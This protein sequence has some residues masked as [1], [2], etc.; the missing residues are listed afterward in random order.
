MKLV[1]LAAAWLGGVFLGLETDV[2]PAAVYLFMGATL[3]LG[4]AV[5]V[6]R[7]PVF[8][9]ILAAFLLAGLWRTDFFQTETPLLA[10]QQH[11]EVI[12]R[13]RVADDPETGI[14]RPR[15]EFAVT[16]ID[17]GDGHE[18]AAGRLLVYA[19]PS[20]EMA[21]RRKAPYFRHGDALTVSGNLQIPSPVD[22]YDYPAYLA[23]RGITGVL[24]AREVELTAEGGGWRGEVFSVRRRLAESLDHALPYPH[25]SL[26]QALLLGKRDSLPPELVERF[27]DTG[28]AHLLAISGL[29]VG[30]ILVVV[31]AA[32]TSVWGRQRYIYLVWPLLAVWAYALVSGGSPPVMRAAAMGTV[33]LAA[34]A[35]GRPSSVLPALAFAAAV[36][37]AASPGLLKQISFQ[38]SFVAVAGIA[39]AHSYGS[40]A[41]PAAWGL[42]GWRQRI[43]RP[44]LGLALVSV[45]AALATWPLVALYFDTV[46]LTGVPITMLAVPAMPFILSGSLL[47]ALLDLASGTLG[48]I[49]GTVVWVPLAYLIE[50]V[51]MFPTWNWQPAWAS[52]W[53]AAGWYGGLAIL[54]MAAR[55]YQVRRY[56]E[57]IQAGWRWSK[58]AGFSPRFAG[59]GIAAI[60][61]AAAASILWH[62]AAEGPDGRLQVDIFDVGQ[63][64]SILVTTPTGRRMLVDGGPDVD[65]ATRALSNAADGRAL[66]LV[67]LTHLDADHSRGL[68]KVL[69]RYEVGAVLVGAAD[70]DAALGPQWQS[71]LAR[72]EVFSV[73]V[74]DGYQVHLDAGVTLDVLNPASAEVR[75]RGA[76]AN[77]DGVVL[78]LAY[79]SMSFLLAAD[80]ERE[81]E[82][83]LANRQDRLASMVIK[84]AHHGSSTSSTEAFLSGVAPKV[85]VIS[86][87]SDN[88]FGHPS[89][90][91]VDRLETLVSP[92]GLFRTDRDGDVRLLTDGAAL[93]VETAR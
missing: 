8:P 2:K 89:P 6:A 11:Q 47:A 54:L 45:A 57:C 10:T 42:E 73:R 60:A 33:Y 79:D 9:V 3:A 63:G 32:S 82:A 90:E 34:L 59:V 25:S 35:V 81:T 88:S 12:V 52:G 87:G 85:A 71:Q 72:H 53:L 77:N 86:V 37:T 92:S 44:V 41:W 50:L 43:G 19:D 75:S 5:Y 20:A 51:S 14:R 91:V 28:A 74:H 38:L 80:I 23:S 64:D 48:Q 78:R 67:V 61:L 1:L 29:H 68:L 46:A 31:L 49:V 22:G 24:F 76:D 66:D 16:S 26:A 40:N 7:L 18:S 4:A 17:R 70:H 36:M 65:S 83:R 69:D 93:W 27:H 84:V 13:G 62:Q 55:P 56:L 30:V 39:L 58:M 21:F 15:F